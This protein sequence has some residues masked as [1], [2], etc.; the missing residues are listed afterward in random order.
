MDYKQFQSLRKRFGAEMRLAFSKVE[1]DLPPHS[2]DSLAVYMDSVIS[3]MY[4]FR[5]Y[6]DYV[7]E[8]KSDK[9]SDN[10]VDVVKES[11][12]GLS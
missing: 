9:D 8:S 12:N 2:F 10:V 7:I 4:R 11:E 6:L 3:V 5:Q 1:E